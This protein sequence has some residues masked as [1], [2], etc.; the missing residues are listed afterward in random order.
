MMAKPSP[1]EVGLVVNV[2]SAL[3][4]VQKVLDY[5][6]HLPLPTRIICLE[7]WGC[8]PLHCFGLF[9]FSI[10][11][12][13]VIYS[14]NRALQLFLFDASVYTWNNWRHILSSVLIHAECGT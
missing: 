5:C 7:I 6:F 8:I 4:Y 12:G 11:L 2:F 9:C 10:T 1:Q 13:T 3:D 14:L